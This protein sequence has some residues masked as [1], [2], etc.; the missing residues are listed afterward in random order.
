MSRLM[1]PP[2]LI[3]A[4][5]LLLSGGAILGWLWLRTGQIAP[6]SLVVAILPVLFL[7]YVVFRGSPL[8]EDIV[9]RIWTVWMFGTLLPLFYLST[10]DLPAL[11]AAN[12]PSW[13]YVRWTYM[14]VHALFFLVLTG[15][16]FLIAVASWGSRVDPAA[17]VPAVSVSTLRQRLN[18][19]ALS[20]LGL[21][22]EPGDS[23][24][25]VSVSYRD[26]NG[27]RWTRLRLR[28]DEDRNRVLAKEFSAINGDAP[29]TESE[30]R[31]RFTRDGTPHPDADIIWSVNWSVTLPK[32]ARRQSLGVRVDHGTVRLPPD[33]A[34]R[35]EEG[36]LPYLLAELV[37]QSGWTWQGV[38]FTSQR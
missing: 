12:A 18:A 36:D 21:N 9:I 8:R 26:P 10:I 35:F 14:I 33:A 29:R 5:L 23:A 27:K 22:V 20:G 15:L 3:A 13:L 30:A 37:H 19:L 16:A 1:I 17:D 2:A 11:P 24:A 34:E 28:L 4:L 6:T 25:D 7:L 38:F 31:M 32:E